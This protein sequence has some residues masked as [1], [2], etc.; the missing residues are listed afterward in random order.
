MPKIKDVSL[1]VR[2][3]ISQIDPLNPSVMQKLVHQACSPQFA[4]YHTKSGKPRM[5]RAWVQVI[6]P[7]TPAQLTQQARLR[8]AVSA[9]QA[10]DIETRQQAKD[11]AKKRGIT[12]YMAFVSDFIKSYIPPAGTTWDAGATTWDAG[13]TLWDI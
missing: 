5:I 11:T 1:D 8:A 10:A 12:L 4:N 13:A 3:T 9:W 7:K 6:N 2:G